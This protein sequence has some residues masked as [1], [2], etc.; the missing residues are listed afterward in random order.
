MRHTAIISV[1][2]SMT[3]CFEETGRQS[4]QLSRRKHEFD[5]MIEKLH[6]SA[7][8]KHMRE[9]QSSVIG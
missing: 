2:A 5:A 3:G 8:V 4:E 9:L 6:S 1:E 7:F